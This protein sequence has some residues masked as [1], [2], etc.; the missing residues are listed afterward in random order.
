MA[1]HSRARLGAD[2]EGLLVDNGAH[3]NLVG[4]AWVER[5][6]ALRRAQG[7]DDVIVKPLMQPITVEG[8][9]DKAPVCT[10]Q[11]EMPTALPDGTIGVYTAPIVPGAQI[12]AL[13]GNKSLK[14]NRTIIDTIGNRILFLGEGDYTI[15]YPKGTKVYQLEQSPSGHSMLPVTEFAAAGRP[16]PQ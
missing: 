10:H 5:M 1:W 8:V 13:F 12:P 9:G 16:S 15:N 7:F 3:D 2:R 11:V 4:E 6:I 14:R